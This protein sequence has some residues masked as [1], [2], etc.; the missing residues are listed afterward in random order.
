M[1]D[2]FLT[3]HS[4]LSCSRLTLLP[5]SVVNSWSLHPSCFHSIPLLLK[6]RLAQNNIN[7]MLFYIKAPPSLLL[8]FEHNCIVLIQC[9]VSYFGKRQQCMLDSFLTTHSSL[10]RSRLTLL[11]TSVSI[12]HLSP[13]VFIL[14]HC[15][16]RSDLH[17]TTLMTCGTDGSSDGPRDTEGPLDSARNTDV[18]MDGSCDTDGTLD[19]ACDA[20]GMMDGICDTDLAA[21]GAFLLLTWS[22]HDFPHHQPGLAS[23]LCSLLICWEASCCFEKWMM[24]ADLNFEHRVGPDSKPSPSPYYPTWPYGITHVLKNALSVQFHLHLYPWW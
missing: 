5:T 18:A 19:G 23:R 21:G 12:H 14:S 22:Y 16:K 10:S 9:L 2:S 6:I 7:A 13:R 20:D 3:T 15:S 24:L 4:S 8:T 11:P 17:K 1:L